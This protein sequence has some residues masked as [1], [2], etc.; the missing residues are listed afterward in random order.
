[1]SSC[2]CWC[3]LIAWIEPDQCD[4]ANFGVGLVPP[5]AMTSMRSFTES[6]LRASSNARTSRS[7]GSMCLSR[8]RVLSRIRREG[9][10]V[11]PLYALRIA[12]GMVSGMPGDGPWVVDELVGEVLDRWLSRPGGDDGRDVPHQGV[13]AHR[14]AQR[15]QF[16]WV[17]AG[18]HFPRGLGF[19]AWVPG[20]VFEPS[21]RPRLPPRPRQ[22]VLR[23]DRVR[24]A[25]VAGIPGRRSPPSGRARRWRRRPSARRTRTH[26]E[27]G[28]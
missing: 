1:M 21:S 25:G 12:T 6:E 26:H 7:S 28:W 13:G 8:L 10:S 23:R 14:R 24:P 18:E 5:S 11:L 4:A 15:R 3:H 19:G 17:V 27:V 20:G 16:G 9:S 22:R 2:A